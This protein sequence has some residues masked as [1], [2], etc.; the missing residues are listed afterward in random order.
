MVGFRSYL[1]L[2]KLCGD[3][4][5]D[6]VRWWVVAAAAIGAAI[7]CKVLYWFED[8]TATLKNWSDPRY[9]LAGKTIVGGLLGGL[10]GV[11]WIKSRLGVTRSTGDLFAIPLALGIAVGRIGCFLTG[12][13]DHTYGLPTSLPWGVNFGDGVRRHPTQIYEILFLLLLSVLLW[14]FMHLSHRNGDVFKVFMVSYMTW[15]LLVDFLKPEI[16]IAIFSSIQWACLLTLLY[17]SGDIVRT[18]NVRSG[19]AEQSAPEV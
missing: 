5:S 6:Y 4:V 3:P 12:L 14:K 9:L 11:E 7:G 16:R 10:I 2:R 15:R 1:R 13:S 19:A 18:F 17:Y 8:P